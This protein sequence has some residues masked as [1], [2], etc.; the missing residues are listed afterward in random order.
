[1]ERVLNRVS[2]KAIILS[3]C[4]LW[5]AQSALA[6][7]VIRPLDDD[8]IVGARA[9]VTGK[10]VEIQSSLDE[11]EDR[12]YTY[13][14]VRVS[15]VIKGQIAERRITIKELGG[16]VGDR[17]SVVYG[18]PQ[19]KRGEKV[20]L[21]LSTRDDGSLRTY[22][23]FLGKFSLVIDDTTG[24]RFAVRDT[25]GENVTVIGA[26][27]GQ[28][29]GDTTDRMELL[30]YAEM[31]RTKLAV[32]LERSQAFEEAYFKNTP[33]LAS[34]P[35]FVGSKH[36]L[37][38]EY[39]FLGN[40][41][42]FQPDS[43]QPVPY[44]INPNPGSPAVV[45]NA[46][47]MAAAAGAWSGVPGC[48]LNLTPSGNLDSCYTQTGTPAINL[49][50]N[51]CDGMNQATSG[52][53]NILAI[54]GWSG[55]G[56]QTRVLGGI[57]FGQITQGFV[58]FNPWASCYFSNACNLREVATHEI[59]HALGFGHSADS[60]ATM[61][62]FA[63]FDGRCASL[64]SDDSNGAAFLYPGSSGPGP[65]AVVTSSLPGGT[66]GTSYSQTLTGSGGTLPYGWSLVAGLG[67]LPPGLGLSSG[68]VISGNPTTVGTYNFTVKVTDAVPATAQKALS[69]AVVVAGVPL[70]SQFVSQ[71]TPT[72]AT[73][74]QSMSVNMKFL[75][76]GTET[77][78]GSVFYLASQNPAL[79]SSWGGNGVSL[80]NLSI[81]PGQQL[82]LTFTATAPSVSGTH[83][84][85]WQLYKNDGTG[86]FG[87]M[88]T[89]VAIQVGSAP[90]PTNNAVFLSQTVP[91][92]MGAGRTYS[93]SVTMRNSG[94]S[95]WAAG[96]YYLGSQNSQGNY[97][98]SLNRVD[99]GSSV[100][101]GSDVTFAFNVNAPTTLAA[102]NFQWQ[103]AQ[104]GVGYFGA[105]STNVSVNVSLAKS[106]CDFDADK[107]VDVSVWRPSDGFWYIINSS[108]GG[109]RI[110]G[111]GESNDIPVPGDYD[112]DGKSDLAIWRPSTGVWWII[113]SSDGAVK[114]QQWGLAGDKPVPGDYDGEGKT[115]L[116]VWRPSN[117]FW[118]IIDSST[119]GGRSQGWGVSTDIPVPADYNGDGKTDLG[120]WRPSTGTWWIINSSNGS[121]TTKQ[122]GA[123][124]DQPVPSDY[125][126]D[127]NADLAVWRPSDGFWYIINSSTGGGRFQ[128]WGLVTDVLVP[129]DYD[130]DGKSDLAVWRPSDGNW[131]IIN[132]SNGSVTTKQWG[133][134]AD[135]PVPGVP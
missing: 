39:T 123:S 135:K 69:I 68:G 6:T 11:Q 2:F 118:Y 44:T 91:T 55:G 75:N 38:P 134:T 8:M 21:Y 41:R 27:Q 112:G 74:G 66:V 131:W 14:T 32:N 93:V 73:P 78:G 22:Q 40:R 79:N 18:S 37:Q 50:S 26:P 3:I 70:A 1:M 9:I 34:P 106:L 65:L 125:D 47:D 16:V 36:Q 83:N 72:T 87:Q 28:P 52:C 89:N 13:I 99:L 82:D 111:W 42:W 56:S 132:S 60:T 45:L 127:G 126:G 81:G 49:V 113:N 46:A 114:S 117:G 101:P 64:R 61:A 107:K 98:W 63:H 121:V 5:S 29:Q 124:G 4:L 103:M 104:D 84:F 7:T 97:T 109:G 10:V 57:T 115:D 17:V 30:A 133:M 130:G 128:G 77:W 120:I 116:A 88:S 76:T 71:T 24:N 25:G 33:V 53:A 67:S 31:V 100:A 35:G 85:Q 110:Q 48:S 108:T 92:S 51:N 129:A 12:I 59:G 58:S 80:V 86:F 20:L 19:F 96:S 90:P 94:T 62:A 23:L 105:M 95:T 122:W 54:G 102:Y 15:E 119:G 43:G